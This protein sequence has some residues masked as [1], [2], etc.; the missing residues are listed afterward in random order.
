M[1][2]ITTLMSV[3]TA[4]LALATGF[5]ATAATTA[6]TTT[7]VAEPE[8]AQPKAKVG[9]KAPDFELK[10]L[11][12][13]TVR[14]SDITKQKKVIVLEWFNPDCPFV[15]MHYTNGADTMTKVQKQFK[16][17]GIVW[18]RINSGGPG[19]QGADPARN[20]KFLKDNNVKG[21]VLLDA[22]GKVGKTYQAK[23]TPQ[24][25]VIGKDGK[26]AYE[27]AP[28]NAKGLKRGDKNYIQTVVRELLADE[29]VTVN[30]TK[31]YGCS[32]KYAN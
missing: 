9:A 1:K 14:L 4:S 15:K 23:R 29:T 3:A 32:V 5:A 27:G 28:D 11:D 26:I 25:F 7:A 20:K 10:D 12:G 22:K 30:R 16:D 8:A 21:Q 24:V 17:D 18:L 2:K 13:K 6:T 31:A 19:K